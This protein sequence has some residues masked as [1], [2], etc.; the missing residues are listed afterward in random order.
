MSLKFYSCIFLASAAMAQTGSFHATPLIDYASGQL[1]LGKYAGLLYDGSNTPPAD[2]DSVAR[3]AAA[4][5]Q[6]LNSQGVPDPHGKIVFASVGMS[7]AAAEWCDPKPPHITCETFSLIGQAAADA[8]VNHAT[9]A[10]VNG[11]HRAITAQFWTCATGPCFGSPNQ[12]DRVRDDVLRPAGLTEKQ[13]QV[14]WLKNADGSPDT[15]L[16][17]GS[18][19]DAFALEA[20]FGDIVRAIRTRWPNVKLVFLASRIYAGYANTPLNPEPFAYES[21]FSVK[22]LINAQIQ[23]RRTGNVDP[24]AGD[25]IADAPV[26]LWGP[27]LWGNGTQNLKGSK[28]LAWARDQLGADG[29]HP[30][31]DGVTQVGTALLN[32]FLASPYAPWFRASGK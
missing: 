20:N 27:Y 5:V 7:N 24:I 22:W 28:A 1:Y 2:Q 30:S 21:G 25:L 11:A 29:T 23:Q 17:H 9:L 31:G 16:V 14:V 32:Y 12:F 13:V 8:Q 6:T 15:S 19:A 3:A 18:N 10:I 26:L 4:G